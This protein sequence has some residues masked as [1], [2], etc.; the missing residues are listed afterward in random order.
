MANVKLFLGTQLFCV[1]AA[2]TKVYIFENLVGLIP[3]HMMEFYIT[4]ALI[5]EVKLYTME[6]SDNK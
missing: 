2:L 6:L 1:C 3:M 5:D 4:E